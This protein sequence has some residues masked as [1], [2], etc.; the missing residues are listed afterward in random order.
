MS[1]AR[2]RL[3]AIQMVSG[4]DVAA[5]LERAARL[6]ARAAADGA[7]CVAL[8]E[9]FA[10]FDAKQMRVLG[11]AERGPE[12][13]LRGFLAAQARLHGIWLIGG[14]I[15][16]LADDGRAHAAC[17]LFAP[18][19]SEAARYDKMHLF[20]VDLPDDQGRYR[21]SDQCAPGAGVCTVAAGPTRLG[22]AVCYDLRFP[23]QFRLMFQRGVDLV[24]LPSAFTRVTG[25]A[26]WHVL[27]R[28]RAIENQCYIVAPDQGGEHSP[29]RVTWGGSV[30]IDPWGRVLASAATGEAVIT[31][32]WDAA[33]LVETRA[34]LPVRAHQRLRL[35]DD[36]EQGAENLPPRVL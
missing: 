31:A 3:A 4:A 27:L 19:G 28:A 33:V 24:V 8:P 11:A 7:A 15:P 18:D 16:V 17:L 12:P 14:T 23:E 34:R 29:Q 22:L 20:D 13:P 30:I 10:C 26:H 5:N 36:A 2:W 1:P 6:I 35:L 32:D 9:T 25:A 21:E